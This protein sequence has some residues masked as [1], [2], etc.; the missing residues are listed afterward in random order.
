MEYTLRINGADRTVGASGNDPLLDVLREAGFT[1]PKRGCR[2]GSC[3]FCTVLIDGEPEKA[4]LRPV[5]TV[6]DAEIETIGALGSQDDL[7]PIQEAFVDSSALQCGFCIP[8]MIMR[9]KGLLDENPDPDREEIRAELSDNLCRCTGYEKI[10]DA[11]ETAADR[12][13]AVPDGGRTE[14]ET[15]STQ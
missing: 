10:I 13:A 11:V 1:G 4:C 5:E 6:E 12:M 7:H 8:G 2:S 3:G 14:S 15:E 9:T